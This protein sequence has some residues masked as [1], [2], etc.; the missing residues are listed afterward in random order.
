MTDRNQFASN[1]SG[2]RAGPTDKLL[3]ES[4]VDAPVKTKSPPEPIQWSRV[5]LSAFIS[6]LICYAVYIAA[7]ALG[8]TIFI[9]RVISS[10]TSLRGGVALLQ[11]VLVYVYF[12][13]VTYIPL[14]LL[15]SLTLT[16]FLVRY[17]R[18]AHALWS[19]VVSLP[20]SYLFLLL[21]SNHR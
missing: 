15:C 2:V 1:P 16:V 13:L 21:V 4:G 20:M 11:G 17:R 10:L 19:V 3:V 8:M 9:D 18:L 7:F 5:V 14:S 12:V 6:A